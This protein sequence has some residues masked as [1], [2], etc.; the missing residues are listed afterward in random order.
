[1]TKVRRMRKVRRMLIT[2]AEVARLLK[3]S[4]ASV[5]RLGNSGALRVAA[6][7]SGIRGPMLFDPADVEALRRQRAEA[8]AS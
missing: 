4:R 8:A 1:M 7:G 2:T 6:K 5:V 3:V